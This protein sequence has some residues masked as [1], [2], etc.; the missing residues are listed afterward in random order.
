MDKFINKNST[1]NMGLD[2]LANSNKITRAPEAL[3][4]IRD[5]NIVLRQFKLDMHHKIDGFDPFKKRNEYDLYIKNMWFEY[6]LSSSGENLLNIY[7]ILGINKINNETL[8][9]DNNSESSNI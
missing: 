3:N 6:L 1:N 2:L 9:Y 5:Y 4:V 8:P 7:K